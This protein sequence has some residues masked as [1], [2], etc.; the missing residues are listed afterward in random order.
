MVQDVY[1]WIGYLF[2]G[3]VGLAVGILIV[4]VG[5]LLCLCYLGWLG[6]DL[7]TGCLF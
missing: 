7:F 1:F 6:V 5:S 4:L 2:A 3:C